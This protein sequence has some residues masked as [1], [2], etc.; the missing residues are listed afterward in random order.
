MNREEYYMNIVEAT[1]Q[2]ATC[3]RGKSG[4]IIVKDNRILTTGYVGAPIGLPHC[5][6]RGHEYLYTKRK[7]QGL[8]FQTHCIRTV[9]AEMNAILQAARFGISVEGGKMFC[10]MFP[11]YDCAK[12]IVNVG[13]TEVVA[14]KDYQASSRSKEIFMDAG[15]LWKILNPVFEKY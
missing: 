1:R 15:I 10:S 9:H 12:A 2:R 6:D 5:S 11:C 3:D 8:K 14:N 4:A 7:K 13:I